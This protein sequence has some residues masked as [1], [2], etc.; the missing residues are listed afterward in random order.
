MAYYDTALDIYDNSITHLQAADKAGKDLYIGLETQDLITMKQGLR[1]NTFF[2]EGWV[3]MELELEEVKEMAKKYKSFAGF[4]IHC[5]D[6]YRL[7]QRGRNV[8]EKQRPEDIFTITANRAGSV[9]IDAD[10]NDWAKEGGFINQAKEHVVYGAGSWEGIDDLSYEVY[11]MW[12]KRNLYFAFIIRDER[13]IQEKTGAAMWKGDHIELWLDMDLEG[14]FNEA[15]NSED[16]L[17]IGLSPGNFSDIDEEIHIWTPAIEMDYDHLVKIASKKTEAG[18]II[19]A[20]I[21]RVLLYAKLFE[22]KERLKE[23]AAREK[24]VGNLGYASQVNIPSQFEANLHFGISIDVSD[25]DKPATPQEA[26]MSSTDERI[27]GDPTTFGYL[28]LKE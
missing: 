6:S 20:R 11:S 13:V 19:E 21:P 17:Q 7:L 14:D 18:Y 28:E 27:W 2:E 24:Q 25:S 16:D 12:D 1:R 4:A 3:K 22:L 5:Y 26:L 8:S 15:V 9:E 23:T 10:L